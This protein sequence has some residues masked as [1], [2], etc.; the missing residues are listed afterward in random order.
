[1]EALFKHKS[2]AYFSSIQ[3]KAPSFPLFS[4][5]RNLWDNALYRVHGRKDQRGDA[6]MLNRL[7]DKPAEAYP[8]WNY[9]LGPAV[10]FSR[11]FMVEQKPDD[12]TVKRVQSYVKKV[13]KLQGRSNFAIKY[14]GPS[15][16]SYMSGLFPEGKYIYLTRNFYHVLRSFMKV[17]FWQD[18]A[19]NDVWWK[20]AYS[21][22][23]LALL[24]N[25]ESDPLLHTAYQ[26]KTI[27]KISR[28]EMEQLP[29]SSKVVS[30]EDFVKSPE[31]IVSEILRFADLDE[32]KDCLNY[33]Q[34]VNIRSLVPTEFADFT[35]IEI[36]RIQ[37]IIGDSPEI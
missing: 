11:S 2:L 17:D 15:R 25:L 22:E 19:G 4:L 8:V 7:I 5:Y 20:G 36:A 10:D 16:L 1:M 31:S 28:V 18:R 30:Y 29:I 3:E 9:L 24:S 23:E 37:K 35:D 14:T 26:L 34:S 12:E 33:L 32:G 21:D 13:C 27:R 6:S